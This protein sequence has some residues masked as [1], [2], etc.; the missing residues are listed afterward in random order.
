MKSKVQVNMVDITAKQQQRSATMFSLLVRLGNKRAL[1]LLQM[2]EESNGY[3]AMRKYEVRASKMLP[4]Q[5]LTGLQKI[6]AFEFADALVNPQVMM[7]RIEEFDHMVE[8]HETISAMTLDDEVKMAVI[9][10]GIPEELTAPVYSNPGSFDTYE[11]V[12]GTL[13]NLVIG[14]K[15][16]NGS[17]SEQVPM[18]VDAVKGWKDKGK[19]KGKDDSKYGTGGKTKGG[20]TRFEGTCNLCDKTGHKK[21]DCWHNKSGEK[22]KSEKG[23]GMGKQDP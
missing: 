2:S 14:R 17:T 4:G 12:R 5:N 8:Q 15:L 19:S 10:R 22:G 13:V 3:E 11:K 7:E 1:L 9:M 23:K 20:K 6:L 16:Y 18:E 21:E